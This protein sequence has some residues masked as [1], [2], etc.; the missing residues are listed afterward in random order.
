MQRRK[1]L[2]AAVGVA[3]INYAACDN[4]QYETSGNLVAP[5]VDSGQVDTGKIDSGAPD[6][7]ADASD[8]D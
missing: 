5:D 6:T 7:K 8:S 3:T 2:I 1:L 4:R